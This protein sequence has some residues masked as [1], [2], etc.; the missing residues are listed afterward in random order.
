MSTESRLWKE[1]YIATWSEAQSHYP[2][3]EVKLT[4]LSSTLS[5]QRTQQTSSLACSECIIS[6]S[7]MGC[8]GYG[9]VTQSMDR[10]QAQVF[11][12]IYS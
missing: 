9:A 5:P 8:R 3:G 4:G 6:T 2:R 10:L 12:F 11:P 1:L 7:R